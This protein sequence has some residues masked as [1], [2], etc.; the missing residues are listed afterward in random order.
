MN[1]QRQ[2]FVL[3]F[4][5]IVALSTLYAVYKINKDKKRYTRFADDEGI[6]V[7]DNRQISEGLPDLIGG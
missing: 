1:D 6:I 4:T 5:G 2:Y 3:G 7:E